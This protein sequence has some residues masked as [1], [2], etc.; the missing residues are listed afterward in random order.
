MNIQPN[1]HFYIFCSIGKSKCVVI[2]LSGPIKQHWAD[3]KELDMKELLSD[4]VYKEAYRLEMIKWSENQRAKDP[5]YFCDA[6][7][8]MYEGEYKEKYS[9]K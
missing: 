6:A 3:Q 1:L 7:I 4:G 2:H 9:I 8:N 5:G